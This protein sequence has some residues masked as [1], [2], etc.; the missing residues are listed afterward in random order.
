MKIKIIS[1]LALALISFSSMAQSLIEKANAEYDADKFANALE[2]YLQAS[3]EDGVSSD[4]FYNIGNTYYRM[5]ELGQSVLYYERALMLDPRNEDAKS[6]LEYQ[7]VFAVVLTIV[8]LSL[9]LENIIK[10]F[11]KEKRK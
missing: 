5:G 8:I 4:L 6:N 11:W 2:L 3:V 10:F 7:K 1:F 9:I